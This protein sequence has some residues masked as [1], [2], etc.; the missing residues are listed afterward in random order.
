MVLHDRISDLPDDLLLHI[1]SFLPTNLAFTTTLISKRWSSLFYSLDV[2]HFDYK[3]FK[4]DDI[5]CHGFRRF[6]D[7]LMLSPLSPNK[8]LKRF[9]LDCYFE[10]QQKDSYIIIN[11]WLEAAN[12]R[13]I[14]EFRLNLHFNTL[15]NNILIS[16]TLVILN[17]KLINI[18]RDISCVSLPSL[19]TLILNYVLFKSPNDYMDFLSAC[20]ILQDLHAKRIFYT[21]LGEYNAPEERFKSLTLS[22]LVRASIGSIDAILNVF[23]NVEYLSLKITLNP[24]DQETSFKVIPVFQNLIHTKLVFCQGFFH[25]WDTVVELL[26]HSPKLQI[27]FIRKWTRSSSSKE[28]KCPSSVLECVSSH[29]RSCTILSFDGLGLASDLQ[30]A[31]YILQNASLLEKMKI[32]NEMLL[33]ES[34]IIKE[35]S[36]CPRK[37]P[38][39][40]LFIQ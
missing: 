28:W 17:L 31:R 1:L 26:Q 18:E 29:L 5:N 9:Y 24:I 11:S 10:D 6:V 15:K 16:R 36:S 37:S 25:I 7:N 27:L 32:S 35:L 13:G 39:C 2:L 19:K 20:P 40:K 12:R 30:F 21:N 4:D 38:T 23:K 34:Q 22:K 33:E 14:E 3:T 8:P